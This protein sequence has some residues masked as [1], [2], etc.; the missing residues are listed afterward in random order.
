[1]L[2][3]STLDLLAAKEWLRRIRRNVI[4]AEL[5]ARHARLNSDAFEGISLKAEAEQP[6]IAAKRELRIEHRK[7]L[8]IFGGYRHLAVA[9]GVR[10]GKT[11]D[12]TRRAIF[13]HGLHPHQFVED[14]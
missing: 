1:M 10:A 6:A 13:L 8:Q 12:P 2:G 9:L 7:L 14:R 3:Q 11:H 4:G 5:K